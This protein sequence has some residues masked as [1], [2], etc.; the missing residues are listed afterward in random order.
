MIER[1][2][3][4]VE[5][6]MPID[7]Q[8]L[9]TSGEKIDTYMMTVRNNGQLDTFNPEDE[10]KN[11]QLAESEAPETLQTMDDVL[12][13]IVSSDMGLEQLESEILKKLLMKPKGIYQKLRACS[14]SPARNWP[15]D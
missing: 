11:A 4:L 6:G 8:H 1:A 13:K 3:I 10:I 14:A 2:V 12:S 15:I 7:I 5:P 9:F